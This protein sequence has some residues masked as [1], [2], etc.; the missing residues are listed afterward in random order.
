MVYMI[1]GEITLVF[2]MSRLKLSSVLQCVSASLC[3]K[4]IL[5]PRI[6][7]IPK[8]EGFLNLMFGYFLGVPFFPYMSRIHIAHIGEDSSIF[9]TTEMFGDPAKM[10]ALRSS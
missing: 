6:S 5:S 3:G 8:I 10:S 7:G 9:G 2:W 4:K 1:H